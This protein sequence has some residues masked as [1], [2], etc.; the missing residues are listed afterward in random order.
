[1]AVKKQNSKGSTKKPRSKNAASSKGRGLRATV[2]QTIAINYGLA[3]LPYFALAIAGVIIYHKFVNR[4]VERKYNSN[5]PPSNISDAEAESRANAIYSSI[6]IFTND[7][8]T[9]AE[10]IAGLNYNGF[11]KLYNAFGK[12]T[13]TLFGGELD[14]ES[15]CRNQF[16]PDR[17]AQLSALTNGVFFK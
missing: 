10:N 11:I 14:L 3:L 9:V 15:W 16:G 2:P 12:H 13:G 1:M 17:I 7:F 4:F 6:G 8:D 5:Y